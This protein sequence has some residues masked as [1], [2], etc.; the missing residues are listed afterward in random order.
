MITVYE[1]YI[2]ETEDGEETM[3]GEVVLNTREPATVWLFN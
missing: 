3:G 2:W 1:I